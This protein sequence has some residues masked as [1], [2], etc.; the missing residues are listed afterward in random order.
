MATLSR[1]RLARELVKLLVEQPQR[2]SNLLKMT[3]AYLVQTK[4]AHA[5]H[6]LLDDMADELLQARHHLSAEVRS[7]FKLN[8]ATRDQIVTMLRQQTGAQH[9]ELSEIVEPDLIG[10]VV[11]RTPR[12]QLDASV[13]RQLMQLAGGM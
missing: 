9:V 1:R 8:G 6:L 12:A 2:T 3:A 13:K 4:Q 11:I 10:G 5:A 7:A